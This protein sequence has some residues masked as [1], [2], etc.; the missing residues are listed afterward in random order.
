MK[1]DAIAQLKLLKNTPRDTARDAEVFAAQREK[2]MLAIGAEPQQGPAAYTFTDY[3]EYFRFALA[4]RMVRSFAGVTAG[5]AL[6]LGSWLT[7]VDA[8]AKSLPGDALYGFK[9]ATE[10]AQLRLASLERRAVLHT[11][12]AERRLQEVVSIQENGGIASD[13]TVKS[14][15]SAFKKEIASAN[16][17]LHALRETGN[18]Q[19]LTAATVVE[20]KLDQL[21]KVLDRVTS[22]VEVS[23]Q[24]KE[25]KDASREV[26]STAV[27][28]A[29]DSH[30][31]SGDTAAVQELS[32]MFK[33]ELGDVSAR[34]AF[35]LQRVTTIR[36]ASVTHAD[37][38]SGAALP[39][40]ADLD[41]L[42]E[43][44]Q[45]AQAGID[46]ALEAFARA[47]YRYAFERLRSVDGELLYVEAQL[48]QTEIAITSA[49]AA[50]VVT[51]EE[52]ESE[53]P[54][55][56]TPTIPQPTPVT[57]QTVGDE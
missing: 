40:A 48:A 24:V 55:T 33:R 46:V 20:N 44:I 9:I 5:F 18:A 7:T 53:V 17:S 11:E 31:A 51:P 10:Q 23:V 3:F 42:F 21:D 26:Q 28:V 56:E 2:L 36:Q 32:V 13:V 34:R 54:E 19:A 35:D 52:E 38:L 57:P 1:R 4:P 37:R 27:A 39:T 43:A 15:F 8:A 6:L 16:Q 41:K 12:F 47:D 45:N 29:V 25:A 14:A 22:G 49:L 30:E 50:P